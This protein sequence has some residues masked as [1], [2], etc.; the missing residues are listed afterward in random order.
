MIPLNMLFKSTLANLASI[1]ISPL[2]N[3]FL[4]LL[5]KEAGN[6]PTFPS[7]HLPERENI[8]RKYKLEWMMI[9]M[10]FP[11]EI[12]DEKVVDSCFLVGLVVQVHCCVW[13]RWSW[14]RSTVFPSSQWTLACSKKHK[15]WNLTLLSW[16]T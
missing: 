7:H 2:S 3:T 13:G 9:A 4:L 15:S 6:L 11:S 8:Y 16:K 14:L 5:V 10:K 12:V 1:P